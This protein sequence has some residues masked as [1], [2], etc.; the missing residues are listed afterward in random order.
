MACSAG[1]HVELFTYFSG[2]WD[3]ATLCCEIE[4]TKNYAGGSVH[5]FGVG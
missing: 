3:G 1:I 5:R 4:V 2:N